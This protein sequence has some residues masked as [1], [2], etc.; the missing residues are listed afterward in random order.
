MS[1]PS[2]RPCL[3]VHWTWSTKTWRSFQS[4]EFT[5]SACY[6][7]SLVTVSQVCAC[8]CTC[9]CAQHQHHGVLTFMGDGGWLIVQQEHVITGPP[10]CW[11]I[12]FREAVIT[13]TTIS[14]TAK[15]HMIGGTLNSV[16]CISIVWDKRDVIGIEN[17]EVLLDTFIRGSTGKKAFAKTV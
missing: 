9:T 16:L 12:T 6:K 14:N 13:R 8:T 17:M 4:T 10:F 5:F 7:Q 15:G 3:S 1:P 2:W 11:V